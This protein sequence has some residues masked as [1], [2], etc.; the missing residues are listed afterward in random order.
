MFTVLN[1]IHQQHDLRLVL[2]AA[3]ICCA[4]VITAFAGYR[5]SL[6]VLGGFRI[7]WIGFAGLVGG[8]GVWATHFIAMLAY[9]PD[10]EIRYEPLATAA[11]LLLSIL[12]VAT[13]FYVAV[14]RPTPIGRAVGG[15]VAG[16]GVGVMHFTGMAAVRTHA[17]LIWRPG[18]VGTSLVIGV[19]GAAAALWAAGNLGT[20]RAA[21][22]AVALLVGAI[23]GL[24]FTAMAAVTLLPNPDAA[25][26]AYFIDRPL[27]AVAVAALV[28]VVILAAAALLWVERL[29]SV[30]TLSNLRTAL[31]VVPTAIA[32]FDDAHRLIFWNQRYG[33]ILAAF[34]LRP[35][36][37]LP[38]KRILEMA[39]AGGVDSPSAGWRAGWES[40]T[41]R[42]Q[43]NLV[44]ELDMPDGR[45]LRGEIGATAGGGM[46]AVL[47]DVTDQVETARVLAEAKNK[48]ETANQAKS[49][50]LAMM[51]HEIRTP[52]NGILGMAQ[53]MQ[54]DEPR[55]EQGEQL[56]IIRKS[57]EIL[58][59]I[60][61]DILD[62]AK[63]EAGK[64]QLESCD[65]DM[66]HMVRGSLAAFLPAA[67]KQGVHLAFN[68]EADAKGVFHGDATRIRQLL[69]NL[70]SNAVK[71]TEK[72]RIDL[73]VAY[74]RDELSLRV[75][76]TGIGIPVQHMSSLFEK[77]TQG[78]AS[79][80]RRFGGTGLG[81]SICGELV[82]L[83]G[84]TIT[85][86]SAEGRGSVF[87]ICLPLTRVGDIA[88]P[89]DG[90]DPVGDES[91]AQR[92]I[93][94]LAAE[95][96]EVNQLVLRTL[97]NQAG[98]EPTIVDNGA[99]ALEAWRQGEWDVI[100]LDVQ[101][102]EM[103]GPTA[104]K[105]IRAAEQESGRGRTPIIAVTANA[106]IHQIEDYMA[107]GM[108]DVVTKPLEARRLF[109]A[110]EQALASSP[111]K[112]AAAA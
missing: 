48:A 66:E 40:S 54:A 55:P 65:F 59:S 70:L 25:L 85:A 63:I 44:D 90:A 53:A 22:L 111:G 105:A 89:L 61:N 110:L 107:S 33:D 7:G 94:I 75:A 19:L 62:L 13:G 49:D 46:V 12:A 5:R 64:L 28:G 50:F 67:S 18:Y 58:L 27:L 109:E 14:S 57:G 106:M 45:H 15:A 10:L 42:S 95:D 3:L 36:P 104:A 87:D 34:N 100:L 92:E 56:K 52:L 21:H 6:K 51:S 88:P 24:H 32:F 77:F 83:M 37:G 80:T 1:C 102:P 16:L 9:Q 76:D 72:G 11:S 112:T 97:L 84:G 71:F 79:T 17:D 20:R 47:Y 103:D 73:T 96:N 23:C 74:R 82:R 108:D 35:E 101:M 38:Y 39:A 99:K 81:L 69:Y 4:S 78:D 2:V 29:T 43:G 98:V 60:L 86:E 31:D 30:A 26:P 8:A 93:R 41:V 91:Q 68:I